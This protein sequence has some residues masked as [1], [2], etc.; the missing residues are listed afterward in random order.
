V[1]PA[2]IEVYSVVFGGTDYS[3]QARVNCNVF[4]ELGHITAPSAALQGIARP[5][6]MGLDANAP[7]LLTFAAGE[8]MG[9]TTGTAQA[10]TWDFGV[11]NKTRTLQLLNPARAG[12]TEK[13]ITSTC[14][15]DYYATATRTE[16]YQLFGP[17][18][19]TLPASCRSAERGVAG[20]I[21]GTW[22]END[23]DSDG[24]I[25]NPAVSP[26]VIASTLNSAVRFFTGTGPTQILEGVPLPENVTSM[27]CYS[28][29]PGF[30][31]FRLFSTAEL[32]VASSATGV[33]PGEFPATGFTVY[34]R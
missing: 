8:Q 12:M 33:C 26:V 30:T 1:A 20:T 21:A 3:I 29:F 23:G 15:Y 10:R 28:T 5:G 22:W 13:L 18:P 7:A 9:T 34:R 14:P 27:Q 6:H 25:T 16:H 17:L 2:A 24:S 31:F 11:Y 32:H 19:R 4:I